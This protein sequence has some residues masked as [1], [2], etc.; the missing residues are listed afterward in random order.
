[1]EHSSPWDQAVRFLT[2][3]EVHV[4]YVSTVC[5]CLGTGVWGKKGVVLVLVLGIVVC[6]SILTR[7]DTNMRMCIAPIAWGK[8]PARL[9]KTEVD[10]HQR[11]KAQ[12]KGGSR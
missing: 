10:G 12:D 8:M 5:P 11:G 6:N 2:Q 7:D 1:M 3:G 4:L 9:H